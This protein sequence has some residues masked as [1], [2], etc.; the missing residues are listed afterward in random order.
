MY[1][2][3]DPTPNICVLI[4]LNVFEEFAINIAYVLTQ[5]HDALGTPGE[6]AWI[7]LHDINGAPGEVRLIQAYSA[8]DQGKAYSQ[9]TLLF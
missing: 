3:P 1:P 4:K 6:I 8:C 2:C 9:P 5:I 7:G